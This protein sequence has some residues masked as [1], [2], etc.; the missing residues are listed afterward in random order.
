MN[1]GGSPTPQSPTADG[2]HDRLTLIDDREA[3]KA[4]VKV[5][6]FRTAKGVSAWAKRS[7]GKVAAAKL[8][9][10]YG[11]GLLRDFFY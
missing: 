5:L 7:R 10:G 11:T 2:V 8:S 4:A 9:L 1:S 3:R 6:G